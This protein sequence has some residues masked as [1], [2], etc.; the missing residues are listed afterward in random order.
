MI[1]ELK[2][3]LT[4]LVFK[5]YNLLKLLAIRYE[6]VRAVL[7]KIVEWFPFLR[8]FLSYRRL[9]DYK[10]LESV[11]EHHLILIDV[12]H[13]SKTKLHTGIQRVV[14]AMIKQLKF[15]YALEAEVM[16]IVLSSDGGLWHF[17]YYELSTGT[18]L[19]EVVVPAEGDLFLGLDL[20]AEVVEGIRAGLF[21]D[22]HRRGA[23]IVFTV[24]DILPIQHP[25]WWP[26]GVAQRHERWLRSILNISDII[27][28]VSKS[29]SDAVQKWT[30]KQDIDTSHLRFEW[31]HLGADINNSL[32]TFGLPNSSTKILHKLD[33]EPTF[34]VV[35]TIEP[36]KGLLQCLEAFDLLWAD[37][38]V[39]NLVI[40][41]REGWMVESLV[42]KIMQHPLKERHLFWFDG[43]SDEYLEKIYQTA[44][45]LIAPSEGEGF[46][47][48]LI[49]AAQQGLP[50]IAR[51]LPVFREVIGDYARYF[52]GKEPTALVSCIQEWLRLYI[53]GSLVIT[54]DVTWLT[55]KQSAENLRQIID[56]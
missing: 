37:G 28:S 13:M 41:G 5:L 29:T 20:N 31:I 48:P 46:G 38:Y 55:W 24:H 2:N 9:S 10:K 16:P 35:G 52:D 51:E 49:E 47:L 54:N 1:G 33:E 3:I 44:S 21:H 56:A 36:R 45:C 27:I 53:S 12:T 22:W 23:K 7:K 14:R 19:D 26:K 42:K 43:I 4:K 11:R 40:V 30:R 17:R 32:P 15:M 8:R 34:L 6:W 50:I 39:L 25:K 18:T